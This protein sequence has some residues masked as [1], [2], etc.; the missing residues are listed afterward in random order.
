MWAIKEGVTGCGLFEKKNQQ[1]KKRCLPIYVDYVRK[2][3]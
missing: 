3:M 2:Q 1:M